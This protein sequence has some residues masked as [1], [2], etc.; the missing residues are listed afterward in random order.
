M[1]LFINIHRPGAPRDGGAPDDYLTPGVHID[2]FS[3]NGTA[4]AWRDDPRYFTWQPIMLATPLAPRDSA[5]LS[6]DWHY[7]VSKEAGREGML[8]STTYYLA[9]FYPRVAVYDDYDGWDT[10][11]FTDAQEF[12][13]DFNDYDVT[14][15]V[16]ANYIV[17]GTGT[18]A[19]SPELL[20]LGVLQ[21]FQS[22]FTSDTTIHIATKADLAAKAVTRQNATNTWHFTAT[23]V[24]DVTFALSDHYDW[25]GASVVVDDATHRRASVQAAYNDT[26]AD[27]HHMVQFGRHCSTGC[28]TTGPVRPTR[29]RRRRSCTAAPTWNTR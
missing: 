26:A 23:N 28:R 19:N 16:P 3:V 9:Y 29:T 17:W 27:F 11:N 8:D 7:E 10:M 1:K 2:A 4:T 18:L 21:R 6:V 20:Q 15:R 13:S 12:Y 25:D 24:P 14:V 22:S 5:R